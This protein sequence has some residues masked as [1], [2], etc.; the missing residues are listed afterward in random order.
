MWGP[1]EFRSTGTLRDFDHE[2]Y[3]K[4]ISGPVLFIGG[5]FDEARPETMYRFQ[6]LV[7]GSKVI[8]TPNA[9]HAQIIDQPELLTGSLRTFM[10]ETEMNNK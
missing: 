6:K 2:D 7:P 5:Q 1:T 9:G 10:S 4:R 3:L 8:I